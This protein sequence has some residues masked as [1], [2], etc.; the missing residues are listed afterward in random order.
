MDFCFDF[1]IILIKIFKFEIQWK[2]LRKIKRKK[3]FSS[4]FF[5]SPKQTIQSDAFRFRSRAEQISLEFPLDGFFVGNVD[6]V[7]E[8]A[9]ILVLDQDT[10]L[11]GRS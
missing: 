7:E 6:S 9:N 3:H 5:K 4:L 8:F 10:L 1:L 2:P 11:D